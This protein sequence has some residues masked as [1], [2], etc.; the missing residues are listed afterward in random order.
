MP[1][2]ER[3]GRAARGGFLGV[4]YLFPCA[5]DAAELARLLREHRLQQV[6][7]KLPART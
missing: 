7:Y 2:A 6:P 3:F 5:H 1:F 4:E